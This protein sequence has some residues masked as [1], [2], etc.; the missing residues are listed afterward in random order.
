MHLSED[1]WEI[2]FTLEVESEA[3][4]LVLVTEKLEPQPPATHV[5]PRGASTSQAFP[6]PRR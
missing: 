6:T 5:H 3:E 4:A 2:I 1:S